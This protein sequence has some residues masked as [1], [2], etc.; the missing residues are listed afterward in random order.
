M[1]PE[2]PPSSV[3]SP[4]ERL[5]RYLSGDPE[6][7]GDTS[8][9]E[10]HDET[11]EYPKRD[12]LAAEL[13]EAL[14]TSGQPRPDID[15]VWATMYERIAAD[16]VAPVMMEMQTKARSTPLHVGR[17]PGAA[18]GRTTSRVFGRPLWYSLGG[19]VAGVAAVVAGWRVGAPRFGQTHTAPSTV[20][21]TA[22]GQRATITLPDGSLVSLNVASTLEVPADFASG[23][24]TLRLTGEGG[25]TVT[26]FNGAPFVVRAGSLVTRVLGTSFA[27]RHYANDTAAHVIVRSGKVAVGSLVLSAAQEVVVD[28]RGA[29]HLYPAQINQF[30]FETG[31]LSLNGVPLRDAIPDLSRWYDAEIHVTNDALLNSRLQGVL[32]SGT[33]A[34][35][36][37][38]LSVTLNV[39]VVREGRVLTL[40]PR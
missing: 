23:N 12:R 38:M 21:T 39:R 35:L 5:D 7:W 32:P 27:V 22:N 17:Y 24:R 19:L 40:F 28:A 31:V 1:E 33:R 4:E 6:A 34:D 30:S 13:A 10:H 25:F 2:T 11:V 14:V 16:V 20:Y 26:H 37:S 18:F 8:P 15:R 29:A 36:A 9:E 3:K